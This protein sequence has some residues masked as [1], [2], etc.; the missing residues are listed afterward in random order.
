MGYTCGQREAPG[1]WVRIRPTSDLMDNIE[2]RSRTG[3]GGYI[4]TGS[5]NLGLR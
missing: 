3:Q 5:P 2:C 1:A 4:P